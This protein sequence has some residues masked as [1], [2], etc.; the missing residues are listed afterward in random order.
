MVVGAAQQLALGLGSSFS[1]SSAVSSVSSLSAMLATPA[2]AI[3]WPVG[4]NFG[5]KR[6]SSWMYA[7][8]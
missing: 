2:S 1:T 4:S 7:P 3:G 8:A 5:M 6:G